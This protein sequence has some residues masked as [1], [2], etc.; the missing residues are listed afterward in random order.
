MLLVVEV[1]MLFG[2]AYALFTAKVPQYFF[3][4][5]Y[6][7][8]GTP[9]RIIG[10]LFMIPLPAA[11]IVGF[12]LGLLMGRNGIGLAGIVEIGLIVVC[13]VGG[14]IYG[15]RVRKPK[16]PEYYKPPTDSNPPA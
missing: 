12:M 9:A 13:L 11:L 6:V 8:E 15:Y 4:S 5:N 14:L 3:G 1:A 10:L 16:A 7:V 2:G